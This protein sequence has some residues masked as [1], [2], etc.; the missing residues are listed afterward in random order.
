MYQSVRS[1]LI[2]EASKKN[3]PIAGEFELTPFC[4]LKCKMCYIR[5]EHKLQETSTADW[6]TLIRQAKD[7]GLL[8][9]LF[10]GGEIFLRK[11]FKTIYETTYDMGIRISLFSNATL[12]NDEIIEVLKNRP[13]EYVAVTMYGTTN[14]MYEKITGIKNGFDLFEQGVIKLKANHINV[15]VRTIAIKE[16]YH[17]LD[18]FIAFV[19]KHG[20]L[21]NYYLYVGPRRDDTKLCDPSLHR[22]DPEEVVQYK[23]R[24]DEAFGISSPIEFNECSEGFR[25][26]AGSSAYFVTWD[27]RM[28]PCAMLPVPSV[29]IKDDFLSAWQAFNKKTK[30][31]PLCDGYDDCSVKS[32]CMQCPAR[33]YLEGG[34]DQCSPYLRQIARYMIEDDN[35]NI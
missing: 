19:K 17:D 29:Q 21:T 8:F 24:F 30:T 7:A 6:I 25:C 13:P 18:N 34:F 4:N 28:I 12:I 27:K 23:K 5:S 14:A 32:K 11:D 15:I 31:I 10:T 9:C 1:N 35:E 2:R 33:R 20:F 16:I 26:V 22:L 3:I